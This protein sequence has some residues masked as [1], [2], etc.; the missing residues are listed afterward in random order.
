MPGG[1]MDRSLARPP[2]W[3]R[4]GPPVIAGMLIVGIAA[5][6]LAGLAGHTYR[7]PA[8]RLTLGTAKR[9]P[10]EDFIAIRATAVPFTTHYLTAEQ[11][12]AV[13]QVLAEDGARVKAGQPLIILANAALQLQVASREAD[14]AGQINALENTR[15]QLEDAR[16]RYEHDLLDIEH[17]ISKLKGDLARD[18]ILLD[19]NAIAPATY[20]QEEEEYAYELKLAGATIASRD[21]QRAV[22]ARELAQLREALARL[23]DSTATAR[24]SLDALTIRAAADGQLTALNAEVGQSKAQGAVLGQVD[25]LDRFKISA[26]VDE[27]YLG[28][29]ALGQVALFTI[30]GHDYS[31]RIAKIYPQIANGTF[32]VDLHFGDSTPQ[33]IHTGEAIDI[34][35]QLGGAV[36]ALTLPNG[37]FYQ[38]TGGRWVFVVAAGGRYATRR[39][40]RLG[41]RNPGYVEVIEGL[42]PGEW[43]IVSSYEA[44]QKLD[45]IEIE[46]SHD[47]Q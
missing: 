47:R 14:A 9:A 6:L 34:K 31:A 24:A 18:K 11:G 33:G 41:R 27:F 4:Y 40:V 23:N 17:Q 29:I 5:R 20:K 26:Q 2:A 43:V 36:Q 37:V 1:G 10:F 13:E 32:R 21:A 39:N 45:R 12:G 19:G 38:D 22:R 28:R 8:D 16:F 3:R 25:S 44:F 7:V 35:L 42:E 46:P 30:D 15:L